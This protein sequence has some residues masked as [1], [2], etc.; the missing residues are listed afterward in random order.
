MAVRA[1]DTRF[2]TL[3]AYSSES[4]ETRRVECG[5]R[6]M[7]GSMLKMLRD[8]APLQAAKQRAPDDAMLVHVSGRA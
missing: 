3:L 2:T 4:E 1:G 6:A 8:E 5:G 7:E